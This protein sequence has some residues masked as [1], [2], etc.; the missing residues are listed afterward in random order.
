MPDKRFDLFVTDIDNTVFDWVRYYSVA[1]SAMLDFAARR[2]GSSFDA[3]SSEASEVFAREGSIEYPFVIQELPSVI[4]HYGDDIDALLGE[5]VEPARVIF[6]DAAEPLLTPYEGVVDT[7][8]E[9]RARRPDLPIVA[10]T[11]A[12]R[13]VCMWKLKK[14]GLLDC[15]TAVYGL[16]DP[17]IPTDDSRGRAKVSP[18]ILLKHLKQSN[19]DFKGRI[20][21]LPEEYEKPGVRGLKTVL[22]DHE[23]DEPEG[24][25]RHVL[26][27]GDNLR[28]DVGLGARLGVTTAWA[29]YGAKVDPER[30]TQLRR[31]SPLSNIHKHANLS[32][33]DASAPKPDVVLSRFSELKP[34]LLRG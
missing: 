28:K 32:P 17:K 24:R 25:R 10:L 15:F 7:L 12:P 6:R 27:A 4:R 14:I 23:M 33:D 30:V 18:S 19:F 20:R 21:I 31:F 26:W 22:M 3:L 11:D 1:C 16:S 5:C 2:V 34:L 29:E 13:Y 9:V 8:R